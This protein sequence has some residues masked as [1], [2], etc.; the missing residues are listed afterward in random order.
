[1]IRTTVSLF[2]DVY[3]RA[4][5]KAVD[6]SRAFTDIVNQALLV[7]LNTRNADARVEAMSKI[8]SLRESP[9]VQ[10]INVQKF[11]MENKQELDRRTHI[12]LKTSKK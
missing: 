3:K 2:D 10:K 6:E 1:M 5:K 4:R 8:D 12:I 7:Y 11:V 9:S